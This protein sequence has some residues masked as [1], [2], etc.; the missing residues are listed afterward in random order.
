MAKWICKILGHHF[1]YCTSYAYRGYIKECSRCGHEESRCYGAPEV[2]LGRLYSLARLR[3]RDNPKYMAAVADP[4]I[5]SQNVAALMVEVE[6]N[7]LTRLSPKATG[8]Q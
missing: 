1:D 2:D 6:I 7:N 5:W 3:L 8:Q 4:S